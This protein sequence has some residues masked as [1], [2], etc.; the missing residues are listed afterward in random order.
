MSP[1]TAKVGSMDGPA[2]GVTLPVHSLARWRTKKNFKG[3]AMLRSTKAWN[4]KYWEGSAI[5][6]TLRE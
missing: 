5:R 1:M 3:S 6:T 4:R 2:V